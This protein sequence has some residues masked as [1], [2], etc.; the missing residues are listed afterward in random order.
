MI[1]LN[2]MKLFFIFI[3][4]YFISNCHAQQF[5]CKQG[6]Q[7]Y[8]LL[9]KANKIEE[10]YIVWSAVRKNC[11]KKEVD[12]FLDGLAIIQ[13]TLKLTK[14]QIERERL[15]RDGIK[16]YEEFHTYFPS[17]S[18]DYEVGKAMLIYYN[19]VRAQQ[20]ME[21]IFI[22]LDS[23]FTKAYDKIKDS[24]AINLYFELCFTK[25]KTKEISAQ[26]ITEKYFLVSNM[27]NRL[28]LEFPNNSKAYTQIKAKIDAK[29]KPILSCNGVSSF[30][31]KGFISNK[32]NPKWLIESLELL[33]NRCSSLPIFSQL[34]TALYEIKPTIIA[35]TYMGLK[36]LK[37]KKYTEAIHYYEEAASLEN[38]VAKKAAIYFTLATQLSN[39]DKINSKEFL[40]KS[41]QGDAKMGK[42]YL[43]LAQLYV[44]SVKECSTS[45]FETKAIYYLAIKKANMASEMDP[46]LQP[47]VSKF[48]ETYKN[49]TFSTKEIRKSKLSGKNVTIGCWINEDILIN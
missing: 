17:N 15:I 35:A 5:D 31:E 6:I 29:A 28:Q 33:S 8:Q 10:S 38:N 4:V 7:D 48:I 3:S 1:K 14:S 19:S 11:K 42:A 49:E 12:V 39:V 2:T 43:S 30:Y 16:L 22:L 23:G 37:Q 46:K 32:T 40:V 27:L 24:N 20:Q 44:A 36:S 41:L 25:F 47:Q 13:S 21:E 18:E 26:A 9:L 45:D 34:A